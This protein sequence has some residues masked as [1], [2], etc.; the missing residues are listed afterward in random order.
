MGFFGTTIRNIDRSTHVHYPKN[1]T[2]TEK[3]AP[4]DDS[5]RLYDEYLEKT[6][7]RI[8]STFKLETSYVNAVVVAF[9]RETAIVDLPSIEYLIKFKLN[10]KNEQIRFKLDGF[11]V[12]KMKKMT[13][14]QAD[15]KLIE[16]VVEKISEIISIRILQQVELNDI[17]VNTVK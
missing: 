9:A 11:E 13:P 1:I 10:E 15:Q 7:Q 8:L 12:D 3:R 6:K 14:N 5:I 4:T 2:V 16:M 17:G